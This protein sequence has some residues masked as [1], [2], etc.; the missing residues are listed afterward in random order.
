MSDCATRRRVS[1]LQMGRN[2][3]CAVSASAKRPTCKLEG[4]CMSYR[5]GQKTATLGSLPPKGGLT[6]GSG[7][8]NGGGLTNGGSK[9]S[10][11]TNGNG[12]TNGSGRT[13]GGG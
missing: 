9:G 7:R 4:G 10:G 1:I 6:N 2:L 5:D 11:R 8:T 12:F 3:Y 13:N